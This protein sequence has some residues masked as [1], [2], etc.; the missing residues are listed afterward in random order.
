MN[1]WLFAI[2]FILN[3]TN[4]LADWE[5]YGETSNAKHFYDKSSIKRNGNAVRVW[6]YLNFNSPDEK[7]KSMVGLKE[8]DCSSATVLVLSLDA[9]SEHDLGGTNTKVVTEGAKKQFVRPNS[10][11]STLMKLAC[12]K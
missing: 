9:Y 2:L 8:Y 5:F 10:I 7:E 4:V 11:D 6:N 3:T 12:K 1:K